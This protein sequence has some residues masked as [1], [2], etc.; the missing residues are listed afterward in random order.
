MLL[1]NLVHLCAFILKG[2]VKLETFTQRIEV[3]LTAL[4]C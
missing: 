3:S 1:H 2:K 4:P